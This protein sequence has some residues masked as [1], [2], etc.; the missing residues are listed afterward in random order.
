MS[1]DYIIL[2]LNCG[3]GLTAPAPE[4]EASKCRMVVV[5]RFSCNDVTLL[6]VSMMWGERSFENKPVPKPG[7]QVTWSTKSLG[8]V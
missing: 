3:S 2:A 7:V 4:K 6:T 8:Q 5:M 1:L